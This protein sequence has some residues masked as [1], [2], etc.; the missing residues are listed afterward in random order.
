[1]CQGYN[2]RHELM[3]NYEYIRTDNF[4]DLPTTMSEQ[5]QPKSI[6]DEYNE[7]RKECI[8]RSFKSTQSS[9]I[10]S[11]SATSSNN[12]NT[13]N[14]QSQTLVGSS[15]NTTQ[16]RR[17]SID[18]NNTN[19]N[20]STISN[21]SNRL[22]SVNR[23]RHSISNTINNSFVNSSQISNILQEHLLHSP[24]DADDIDKQQNSTSQHSSA[25]QTVHDAINL[26]LQLRKG[27]DGRTTQNRNRRDSST[28]PL[29][30]T[31]ELQRHLQ[32]SSTTTTTTNQ[33][34]SVSQRRGNSSRQTRGGSLRDS[35]ATILHSN[36]KRSNQEGQGGLRDSSVTILHSNQRKEIQNSHSGSNRGSGRPKE[37]VDSLQ[38]SLDDSGK[39]YYVF[40]HMI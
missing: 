23:R 13:T 28:S 14:L 27:R 30:P 7:I 24:I 39:S 25:P 38:Y 34:S 22:Q 1:M 20:S 19:S 15:K 8:Q 5:H 32:R 36:Q 33:S 31:S 9:N 2:N 21:N 4:L 35:N 3:P 29:P 37:L 26:E 40:V 6:N 10:K 11:S 18:D 17:R 12:A 16:R